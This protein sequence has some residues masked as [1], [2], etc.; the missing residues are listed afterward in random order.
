MSVRTF[1]AVMALALVTAFAG[2]SRAANIF[3]KNFW[4]SGP[5]YD[6]V[7]PLCEDGSV[8]SKIQDRFSTK[9]SRFWNS[10]LQIVGFESVREIS[11]RP[12]H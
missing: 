5:R 6:A 4:L 10:A 8:M 12:G 2:E 7:V 9:E 11:F 3:E 1:A